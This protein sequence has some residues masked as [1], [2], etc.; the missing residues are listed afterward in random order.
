MKVLKWIGI[1]LVS[2]IAIALL[3]SLI[4]PKEVHIERSVEVKAPKEKVFDYLVHFEKFVKWSP[5][6]KIDPDLRYEISDDGVTGA[7][8]H[9]AGNDD[10]GEGEMSITKISGMDTIHVHLVFIKPFKSSSETYYVLEEGENGTKVSWGFDARYGIP[11]N[12]ILAL[13]GMKKA[14]TAD[15]DKGLSQLKT[16]LESEPDDP[17]EAHIIEMETKRY[18]AQRDIVR[19]EDFASFF[20]AAFPALMEYAANH[21]LQISGAPSSVV[22]DWNEEEKMADMAAALPV[23]GEADLSNADFQWISIDAG[24]AV[25]IEFFGSPD[26]VAPAHYFMDEF[27][28]RNHLKLRGPVIEQYL[29]DPKTEPDTGRWQTNII[30][31]VE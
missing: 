1:I 16:L 17:F 30:Y 21:D 9:W 10:V 28:A 8:Y 31:P 15:L 11:M 27:M 6:Q 7:K 24:R 19:M 23:N 2:I 13:S 4:L 14:L 12:L 20:D 29:S 18:L 5:W 3:A 26:A 25:L 22:F